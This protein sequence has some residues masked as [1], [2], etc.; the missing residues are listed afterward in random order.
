MQGKLIIGYSRLFILL[1]VFSFSL[2]ETAFAQVPG[3]GFRKKFQTNAAQV[4]GTTDLTD[5]PV[6]ISLTDTDL[7]T[8]ANGGD[9][10]NSNGFDIVFTSDDGSTL[11]DHDLESYN[12]STGE[13]IAWV[14]FPTLGATT[15]TEFFIYYGNSSVTTD[16]SSS[17]TWDSN[18]QLV[19][20]MDGTSNSTANAY[21]ISD[22]GTSDIAGYIGRARDFERNQNNFISVAND[23]TLDIAGN[24]TI[25]F[26]LN[27][28]S[29]TPPDFVTKGTNESYEATGRNPGRPV[30]N[31]NGG[32]ALNTGTRWNAG[33]WYYLS[34]VRSSTGKFIYID[35]VEDASD[36]DTGTFDLN[37]NPL[38]ISRNGDAVD[39]IMD[40]VRVSDI[41]RSADYIA[42]EYNNQSAPASFITE[43]PEPPELA[44]IETTPQIFNAGGSAVFI[45]STLTVSDPFDTQLQSATIEITGNFQSSEDE[46]QFTNQN[47]ITGSY[48]SGS[49]ILSLSGA[50]SLAN[51]QTAI[52]S[53]QYNNTNASTPNQSTRT[54]SITVN[55]GGLN[56]NTLSR[57]LNITTTITDLSTDL[58]NVVF[59]FDAQDVDG[60]LL[61]ND[62]PTDGSNVSTWGDRSDN[63]VGS[64]TDLSANS[65]SGTTEP[66][67]DSAY[68]GER[69]GILWDGTDDA[70]EPPDDVSLNTGT[71]TEKSF[72]LV[73]RTGDDISGFQSVYE[74]GAGTRGYNIVLKDGNLYAYVWNNAEWGAG[75]QDK[76]IDL[77]PV[78]A[79]ESYIVIASHDATAA[80][81]VNRIWSANVNGG[82]VTSLNTVDQQNA[83]GGDPV[84][85]NEDG[86]LDPVTE[87]APGGNT[88][89]GGYI[90]ELVSWNTALNGGQISS[91][92]TFLDD[93]WSNIPP[94]LSAIE[95]TNLDFTEGD[96]G[97]QITASLIVDDTDNTVLDSAYVTISNNYDTG[98]DVLAFT[99][100]G[101]ITGSFDSGTGRLTMTGQDSEANY[102]T[103][104]RSV[105]FVNN[106][107]SPSTALR[108]VDFMVFDWDDSSNVASRNINV[109]DVNV[110]PVLAGIEGST[111]AYTEGDGA[112][113]VTG[114][115]T[116]SDAD[117]TDIESAT[118][119]ITGNYILGEDELAF[120]NTGNITGSFNS[121]SGVLTLSGTD[122]IA[123][124]QSALRS[125]TY[126][127]TSGDPITAL[128]RTV[129]FT[130][131]DGDANSNTLTRD[132]SVTAVNSAP[133]I[134]NV[135]SSNL[136]YP[137][138]AVQLTNTLTISDPDNTFLDSAFVAI[139]RN[140]KPAEDSL[141]YNTLFGITGN[142]NSTT[143][144]LKLTGNNLISDYEAALRSVEYINTATVAQGPEREIAFVVDDGAVKSDSVF[145]VVDVSPV[146]TI[147][148][149]E[150]WLRAD[151]GISAGNGSPIVTWQDQSGNGN[152]YVGVADAGTAP[153]F[154]ASSAALN[155]QPSVNFAGNGDH[156]ADSDGDTEYINGSTEFTIFVVIK[157]D[158]T[159]TDRGLFIADVPNTADEI[160]TFRYDAS[161]ANQ[162]GSFT[163]VIKTGILANTQANQLES[164]SD[165][166]TTDPQIISL[167]WESGVAYDLFVDGILN[168]PSFAA[169]PPIGTITT[170]TT[171]IL[172][173][174][175]KDDPNTAN[176][177][178]DGEIAEF[179]Y[180]SRRLTNTERESVEDY[181][182]DKYDTPIRKITP[183][184]GGDNISADDA[185]TTFTS[186]TGPIIQESFVG[187]LTAAGA[188]I[189]SAPSGFEWNTSGSYGLIVGP[190]YGGTT[191][192]AASFTSVTAN[193]ITYT[194]NT[195]SS[196]NPGQIE[197]T[198]LEIRPTTGNLPN[199]G[200]ITNT[201]STGPGGNTNYGSI[202]MVPGA[203][204][205]LIFVQQPTTTNID[206]TITPSVRV[207]IADQ[208]GN[209]I[210]QSGVNVNV[211][212]ASGT[213]TLSGT[214]TQAT[215]VLGIAE[216]AD[217][218][219]DQ[220]GTKT[221]EAS[222]TGL[223]PDTSATFDIVNAGTLTGFVIE[224][225]PSG[226]ISSKTAGQNFN[227]T[228]RAVDGTSTTVTTF[229]G[230][231]VI[232][233]G[234]TIGTGQ[235]TTPNFVNGVLSTYTVSI[236]S[237]GSC[238]I[239]ATNSS[240]PQN[241]TSNTFTVSAGAPSAAT[242]T[243]TASPTVILNDGLSTSTITVDLFDQFGNDIN[244]G[245]ATV[246]LAISPTALGS[247]GSV[248]DNSDGTYSATVTSS[249]T[250]G[251]DTIT[252][253]VNAANISDNA[254]VEYA[255]FT[256]IWTSQ[257][258][259]P[260]DASNFEDTGNWNV[261]TLPGPGASILI[262]TN[263]ATG[264]EYPVVDVPGRVVQSISMEPGA[265]I[266][267]SGGINL[268]VTE[269]VS[270]GSV[271]G[272]NADS[273]TVGG[274]ILNVATINVGT[275]VLNGSNRQSITSPF[276]YINLT[277]DNTA[278][279]EFDGDLN[280]SGTLTLTNGDLIIPTNQEFIAD[281]VIYGSGQ[282]RF[283]RAITGVRGWRLISSP[284]AST[285][286][287]LLDETLTQGYTGSTLGAA[288]LDSLQPNV[289]YY[290]ETF[291]GTDN[292]RYRAPAN[293]S[294]AVVEGRG[295]FV[296]FFG[297]VTAD[298]RYNDP[299]PDTL[300]VAGEEFEGDGTEI[301]FPVTYTAAADTGWN[302]VGNPFGS[303]LDWDDNSNWTKTNIENTIYVWDPAANSGNGEYLSWN[304]S[305]GT[306]GSG[307]I[308]P[309]QAFWVKASAA[310]PELKVNRDA[311]TTGGAFLRK[312]FNPPYDPP[313]LELEVTA[314][315]LRKTTT[316]MFS[317][318]A[319]RSKDDQDAYLL[320]PFS[321]S[322]IEVYTLLDDGTQ[323][324]I[325]SLPLNLTNRYRIP[326]DVQGYNNGLP[327]IGDYVIRWKNIDN[328][329]VE[330]I[331]KLID[332]QTGEEINLMSDEGDE[333]YTFYHA[334]RE[335]FRPNTPGP[336]MKLTQKSRSQSTRFTLLITTEEIEANI[337]QQVYLDQNYPNPF[338]PY[339]VIPFGLDLESE[340]RLE[341]F[342]ILGRR[343]ATLAN[344]R[345]QSGRY[346]IRFDAT[347]LASGMY[348][349]RLVTDSKVITKKLTLIR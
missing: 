150:V 4:S 218:S 115:I 161:G 326:L 213:G 235:G 116:V 124:Y 276:D 155:G 274:D 327:I 27:L 98:N 136:P 183:A 11:L 202:T 323:L 250:Q 290:D 258:G 209:S 92:F 205:T 236:T 336:G 67:F 318:S 237:V 125:V 343:V 30:F 190:A 260:S 225:F 333:S 292:Q 338:N 159:G 127:N 51:Y 246:T 85:G 280:V 94:V 305:T 147:S 160:L 29:T 277:I 19:M 165:I 331:I 44:A 304:G 252:G 342:D 289:L 194:I 314:E 272:S 43:L 59:H 47:G 241:G 121:N 222:G 188:I 122:N 75:N 320:S 300:D 23:P 231:V 39:G 66:I 107:S 138:A 266:T 81:L 61:T 186:L 78:E 316:L 93:K 311:R 271:L 189:L 120:V 312:D 181:L 80:T 295:Y 243:I 268:T 256:H 221:L 35:G 63:A 307:L 182:S 191:T 96:P 15:D 233:S 53:I 255:A 16:Q 156:F 187:E 50:S 84:I 234:C 329:P 223:N 68:F 341:V 179:I 287:D 83:H 251:T 265:S 334:T 224:R 162:G 247:I 152:D 49:G 206:S 54:I 180:Y 203:Q 134:S 328:I 141:I 344:Q 317:E 106:S 296:F 14:R 201:G 82:S 56:S 166:Q 176:V 254:T 46:L 128:D 34:F 102:Q 64:G 200:N 57:D 216:F 62:Q 114:S 349:Y 335:K 118:V 269:D 348:I 325:N 135:E 198:G 52:R 170:A 73:F 132:I 89:F 302:L 60:D 142:Y 282:L 79:N 36:T 324:D 55:D 345:F 7:R 228:I 88:A 10:E 185:N 310:S 69:G 278:G 168:N 146:E 259:N 65:L 28:E 244:T 286:G 31:R 208:F 220:L 322:R 232:S 149:L 267:I 87:A 285:I 163:N 109:I 264:N 315:G 32:N 17:G 2:M 1:F 207:Q 238:S 299:L 212:L 293:T 119:A 227:I 20:H 298:S 144:V 157:S 143:G 111:L 294:E 77:G 108:Q 145:R 172:G 37:N 171:A 309:F 248:T 178:W 217:L 18:Y 129:S 173:K 297:D 210:E 33:Q 86:T 58:P 99:P 70:L 76:A 110:S 104:L 291:P 347:G 105:T 41:D 117:D 175:G 346:E 97:T 140:F 240:G 226:N 126:E 340:V 95:G 26:W 204:D 6:L 301:T 321:A 24:V 9:V 164:F 139:A 112:V 303:T 193:A 197:F 214:L 167:D 279:V 137:D 253:T 288:P 12:A 42:T 133:V 245:G 330:W 101:N 100:V 174:G 177:S 283:Q 195:A 169:S 211:D 262:P 242:S 72:A 332:N 131:N 273:L 249:T 257:L 5:F 184:T 21:S 90:G 48:N 261:G 71:Y 229:N 3:Y 151:V 284:V 337:P 148:G 74:Q 113:S 40:E 196:A 192:L 199:S 45:S 13:V 91:V 313:K 219:I 8:T 22:N 306:L 103:A 123:N 270:G 154:V 339:T 308:A 25:S 275:V 158:Q 38:Q 153:T 281:N 319:R 130:V 230:T 215:N 239:T 263:P